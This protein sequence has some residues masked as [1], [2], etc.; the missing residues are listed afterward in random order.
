MTPQCLESWPMELQ[1]FKDLSLH[2]CNSEAK[3]KAR[4][5]DWPGALEQQFW[6]RGKGLAFFAKRGGSLEINAMDILPCTVLLLFEGG[7]RP[8]QRGR[9]TGGR[10][11]GGSDLNYDPE[12]WSGDVMS[13]S[14]LRVWE[15]CLLFCIHHF[16]PPQTSLSIFIQINCA[17][18][19]S[20]MTQFF[21]LPFFSS[22]LAGVGLHSLQFFLL[23]Y[24]IKRW[25]SDF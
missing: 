14:T 17:S 10:G 24:L 8:E 1:R 9:D 5:Q 21:P 11:R 3:V 4:S 20:L 2:N 18:L 16:A 12:L 23:Y 25:F 15:V 6:S 22:E 7:C 19:V 13:L